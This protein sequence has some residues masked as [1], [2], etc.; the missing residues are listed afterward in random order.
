MPITFSDIASIAEDIRNPNSDPVVVNKR[1]TAAYH[2]LSTRIQAALGAQGQLDWC[3]F[4][5]WSSKT[6]GQ[7]LDPSQMGSRIE[8]ITNDLLNRGVW[9][10]IA[11][12]VARALR[13]LRDLDPTAI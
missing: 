1:I 11:D 12:V 5:K 13:E 7:D 8:T 6:V 4:A 2:D 3:G 9:P 10:G